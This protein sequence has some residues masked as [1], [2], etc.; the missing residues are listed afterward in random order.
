M[1]VNSGDRGQGFPERP[2]PGRT[3]ESRSQRWAGNRIG[4]AAIGLG[5][6]V[7]DIVFVV[8]VIILLRL[9]IPK[10]LGLALDLLLI[11]LAAYG[12]LLLV[13]G[14]RVHQFMSRRTQGGF[15]GRHH[16]AAH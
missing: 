4:M 6:A 9:T 11:L 14:R 5:A 7:L 1:I 2:S 15:P 3:A 10:G 13:Y 8:S 16:H 12:I